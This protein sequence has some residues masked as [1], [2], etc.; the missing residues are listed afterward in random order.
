MV[1]LLQPLARAPRTALF[2]WLCVPVQP[3]ETSATL[4]VV[5]AHALERPHMHFT[6]SR[7][8]ALLAVCVFGC[9]SAVQEMQPG[10]GDLLL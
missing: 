7:L 2:Q 5:E 10:H 4:G 1:H 8:C 3:L 9:P 6:L